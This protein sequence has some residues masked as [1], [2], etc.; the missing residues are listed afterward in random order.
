LFGINSWCLQV[1]FNKLSPENSFFRCLLATSELRGIALVSTVAF[2]SVLSLSGSPLLSC[3]ASLPF[4][5]GLVYRYAVPAGAQ[6]ML[7]SAAAIQQ[8]AI[9]QFQPD[10]VVGSSFGGAVT[11]Q[12]IRQ[13]LW[14]GPTLLL[15]PAYM[16]ALRLSPSTYQNAE[17]AHLQ[18]EASQLGRVK[19]VHAM[20]DDTVPIADSRALQA[21]LG[22][23]RVDLLELD[24]DD[25]R[26]SQ[27]AKASLLQH[28]RELLG[29][30]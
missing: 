17:L 5:G 30:A 8:Q 9:E 4:F 24:H 23:D 25:H 13:G 3:A 20:E 7:S 14:H 12:L 21:C 26:L 29:D 27:Y 22:G 6:L 28:C 15:A 2:L 1:S 10:L 11:C 16:A 18:R 19:I